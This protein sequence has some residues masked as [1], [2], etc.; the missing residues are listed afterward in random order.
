MNRGQIVRHFRIRLG[1]TTTQLAMALH[2]SKQY[3]SRIERGHTDL[4]EAK[5][6]LIMGTLERLAREWMTDV[7]Q[8]LKEG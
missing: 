6:K 7:Q 3:V 4:G 5:F 1:V 8:A 2:C